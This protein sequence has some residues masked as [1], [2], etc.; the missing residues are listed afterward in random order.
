MKKERL[1]L[2]G[3]S[4]GISP[5]ESINNISFMLLEGDIVAVFGD[6]H[7]TVN[8]FMMTL[9]GKA[10]IKYG[11]VHGSEGDIL[12]PESAWKNGVAIIDTAYPFVDD[13]TV[14]E[15]LYLFRRNHPKT[16]LWVRED[17]MLRH[18]LQVQETMH[19]NIP[20]KIRIRD[21]T[22]VQKLYLHIGNA[23]V[24]GAKVILLHW[25]MASLPKREISRLFEIMREQKEK[26]VSFIISSSMTLVL[27]KAD[28]VLLLKG[29]HLCADLSHEDFV[30]SGLSYLGGL[31]VKKQAKESLPERDDEA[32]FLNESPEDGRRSLRLKKAEIVGV[33]DAECLDRRSLYQSF[34][35]YDL[36][37]DSEAVSNKEKKLIPVI[38]DILSE[39]GIF[40]NL[41]RKENI[42]LLSLKKASRPFGLLP[43][44][45]AAASK[46]EPPIED[47]EDLTNREIVE[48]QFE[49][50]LMR[51]PEML[52]MVEPFLYFDLETGP[53]IM[54]YIRRLKESGTTVILLSERGDYFDHICDRVVTK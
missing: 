35:K 30:S 34:L 50:W 48:I 9:C 32:Q 3:L 26:G 44:G 15:N 37:Y 18:A 38:Y 8:A 41:S 1:Y 49:R 19:L 42:L 33:L 4:A 39:S 17:V 27:E 53:L 21:L 14:E 36:I 52:V 12:S 25:I 29:D 22:E 16:G 51:R 45:V 43:S 5:A 40:E 6:R 7:E 24:G 11:F 31:R 10:Q 23:L 13:M 28:R 2:R 47:D 46:S 54:E 20:P